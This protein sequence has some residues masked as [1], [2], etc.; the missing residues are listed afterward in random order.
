MSSAS[1]PNLKPDLGLY[2]S[3]YQLRAVLR[4]IPGI[5]HLSPN[6]LSLFAILPGLMAAYCL[7]QGFWIGAMLA[8]MGR[9]IINTLDG[10]I[11]EEYN[12][13]SHLGAYLNRLPGE[14]TDIIILFGLAPHIHALSLVVLLMLTGWVQI[15]G[16]LGLAAG[17][18]TQSV[19]PCGQ[20]DRLAILIV[21]C[22][23]ASFHVCVWPD[24]TSLMSLGCI[25][26]LILRIHRSIKAI[27]QLDLP[28]KVTSL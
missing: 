4:K 20:T 23:I 7:F 27:R 14:F 13:T 16:L 24:L 19:G 5:Q 2:Q 11:A 8:I 10:L 3:K 26:T 28:F 18:P 21:G 17:G 9:M 1:T 15:F 22:L 25:L 6:A 12:K